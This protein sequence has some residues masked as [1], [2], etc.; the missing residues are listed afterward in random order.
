MNVLQIVISIF[1]LL[2]CINIT[3][4]YKYPRSKHC[5]GVGVFKSI[6]E[7]DQSNKD[8]DFIVYLIKWVANA[9]L[10]FIFL[11]I[12]I[13]F[14]GTETL[15]L[16]ATFAFILSIL[17]FYVTLFPIIRKMD[18]NNRLVQH[19]YSTQLAFTIFAFI[20]LL[21]IGIVIHFIM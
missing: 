11:G 7:I 6:H 12:T 5:N 20:L 15:Q 13:V 4:L 14:Y 10:I 2:E 8:Y 1:L 19:G 21:I 3:I 16:Y 9:K 17:V 18:K